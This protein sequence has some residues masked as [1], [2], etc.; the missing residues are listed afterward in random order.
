M[1][2]VGNLLWFLFGGFLLGLSWWL[3]GL[4]WCITIVGIPWGR[5]C[6]KFAKLIFWPFG[7]EVDYGG[8]VFSLLANIIWL[9][10]SGLFLAIESF[11]FGVLWCATI[12]GIPWGLQFFKYAKLALF[13]FG[14]TVR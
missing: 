2:T 13:P 9:V 1:R 14:A 3:A 11:L 8:G 5:Q 7:K 4:L 10:V 6:F 12:V